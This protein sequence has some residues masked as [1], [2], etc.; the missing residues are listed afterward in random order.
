[1]L[2]VGF[3]TLSQQPYLDGYYLIFMLSML[4]VSVCDS[5]DTECVPTR[6]RLASRFKITRMGIAWYWTAFWRLTFYIHVLSGRSFYL[7]VLPEPHR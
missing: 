3:R 4:S 5:T 1:M 2:L 7:P 6:L